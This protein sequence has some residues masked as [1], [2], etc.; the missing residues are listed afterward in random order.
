MQSPAFAFIDL[1][2]ARPLV[3]G[4]DRHVYQ[5]PDDPAVLIKVVDLPARAA[6][7]RK[8]WLKRWYRRYQR[9]C[10]Y[11]TFIDEVAE[12]IASASQDRL[13]APLARIVGIAQTSLG[14]GLLVEKIGD[15][16]GGM[17]PTLTA[18][19]RQQGL[20]PAL[21]SQ[22]DTFFDALAQAHVIVNDISGKNI[23]VGYNAAGRHGMYLVDGFGNKQA[24][25]LFALSRRLNGRRLQRKY[26]ELIRDLHIQAQRADRAASALP[27]PSAERVCAPNLQISVAEPVRMQAAAQPAAGASSAAKPH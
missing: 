15:A 21:R 4:S 22:L 25:P 13:Q 9:A 17:A 1:S 8:H 7:Q 16:A 26:R 5:H 11:R 10:S 18:V 23:V 6:Y 27:P 20:S 19:V 2:R 3:S 12:Y 14:L 24:V